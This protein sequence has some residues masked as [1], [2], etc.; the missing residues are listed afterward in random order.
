MRDAD[1][2]ASGPS[3]NGEDPGDG[4]GGGG[5]GGGG[6]GSGGVRR[7]PKTRLWRQSQDRYAWRADVGGAGTAARVAF[8]AVRN[9]RV[10]A[11]VT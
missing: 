7:F 3:A 11:R 10:L 8:D 5:G 2:D 1:K 9:S 6:H 4:G